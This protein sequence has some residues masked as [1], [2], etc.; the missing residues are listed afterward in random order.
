M[1]FGVVQRARFGKAGGWVFGGG[2]SVTGVQ[3]C[4]ADVF[5]PPRASIVFGGG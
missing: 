3:R 4:G 5:G 1:V 2:F